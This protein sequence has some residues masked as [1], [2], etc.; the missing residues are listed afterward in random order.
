MKSK[1]VAIWGVIGTA[2]FLSF[3]PL[4]GFLGYQRWTSQHSRL[5]KS[6][7]A[8]QRIE[9]FEQVG[10]L[11]ELDVDLSSS[12]HTDL[13][14]AALGQDERF[15]R[16][17]RWLVSS[18]LSG[19]SPEWIASNLRQNIESM[20]QRYQHYLKS[21]LFRDGLGGLEKWAKPQAKP[22]VEQEPATPRT[23]FYKGESLY[24]Q[25]LGYRKVKRNFDAA[26]F[27]L[28]ATR[29]FG[30]YIHEFPKEERVPEAL[31]LLG[32][33]YHALAEFLPRQMNSDVILKTVFELFP[34]TLWA[35]RANSELL[36]GPG[37]EG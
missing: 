16:L 34:D 6:H 22:Q 15:S 31:F 37:D 35:G 33:A 9:K 11:F 21:V 18:T 29:A 17:C 13:W 7:L 14:R 32:A 26:I 10:R 2:F 8:W 4:A 5:Q 30:A 36:R 23:L 28:R 12:L 20:P 1:S 27:Y 25:A 24:F 19:K 3:I